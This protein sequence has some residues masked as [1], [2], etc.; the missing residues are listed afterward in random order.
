M[1]K[2]LVLLVL[3]FSLILLA[4][5]IATAEEIGVPEVIEA[6]PQD[7]PQTEPQ[8]EQAVEAVPEACSVITF[9]QSFEGYAPPGHICYICPVSGSCI[10]CVDHSGCSCGQTGGFCSKGYCVCPC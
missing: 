10:S 9:V 5:P 7:K 3:G 1:Q 2:T 8:T 6:A 4:T